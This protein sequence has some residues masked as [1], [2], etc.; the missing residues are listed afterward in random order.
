MML[1]M[2]DC[3]E[4]EGTEA[5]IIVDLFLRLYSMETVF[6]TGAG[7][8]RSGVLWASAEGSRRTPSH[9]ENKK[10]RPRGKERARGGR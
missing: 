5:N 9:K 10:E 6:M 1:L 3:L 7:E 8:G 2:K 4:A